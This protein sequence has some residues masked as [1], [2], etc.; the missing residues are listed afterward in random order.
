MRITGGEA[1]GRPLRVPKAPGVR[2]T[3]DRVREAL[4]SKLA[5][6]LPGA[7]V[8]DL[9]A[10]SGALGIEALSRGAAEVVFVDHDPRSAAVLA[11]NLRDLGYADRARILREDVFRAA[12]N[13]IGQAGVDLVFADPP[14]DRAVAPRVVEAVAPHLR[15]GAWLIIEHSAREELPD[16]VPGAPGCRRV[17]RRRYGDTAVSYYRRVI[18]EGP[19]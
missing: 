18:E 15:P 13:T 19:A 10:G 16:E 17:D 9:F 4:F 5:P 14:Y 11:G 3:P 1:R 2:P 8:V 12:P 6:W 7:R